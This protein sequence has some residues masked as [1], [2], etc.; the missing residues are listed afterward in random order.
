M[1]R[2]IDEKID[3]NLREFKRYQVKL[4]Q[5]ADDDIVTRIN[6]LAEQLVFIGRL[7]SIF[8]ELNKQLYAY[9]KQ[10][11]TEAYLAAKKHKNAMAEKAVIQIRHE[12]AEAY[13]NARKWNTAF[14]TT[15]EEINALK[16]KF[17]INEADG[18]NYTNY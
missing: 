14:I 3:E 16:Y 8:S 10:V 6:V 7:A 2:T 15:R 12:E 4:R 18:S 5:I 17:K 13:G 11:H 1:G 9:R